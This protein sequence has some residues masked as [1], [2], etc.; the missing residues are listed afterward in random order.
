VADVL[1]PPILFTRHRLYSIRAFVADV[2]HPLILFARHLLYFIRAFLA[3]VLNS[4]IYLPG[5]GCILFV[6]SWRMCCIPYS[7]YPAPA[8]FYSCIRGGCAASPI[9]FTRHL[10]QIVF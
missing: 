6:H 7:I 3:D 8:V 9:L 10:L 2:L 4:L 1:H 5:T